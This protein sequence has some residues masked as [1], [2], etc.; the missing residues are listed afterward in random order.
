MQNVVPDLPLMKKLLESA[1]SLDVFKFGKNVAGQSW[2]TH[3]HL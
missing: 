1:I 3:C 2:D